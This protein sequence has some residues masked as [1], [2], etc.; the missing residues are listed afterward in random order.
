M[1][2]RFK[3]FPGNKYVKYPFIVSLEVQIN[4]A[5]LTNS[6]PWNGKLGKFADL[7]RFFFEKI[8]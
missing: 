6:L 3:A 2:I 1:I 4:L 8:C 7:S 5:A